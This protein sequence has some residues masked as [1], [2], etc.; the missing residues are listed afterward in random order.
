MFV[1]SKILF[2][3]LQIDSLDFTEND[4]YETKAK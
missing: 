3:K 1:L 4:F 2:G